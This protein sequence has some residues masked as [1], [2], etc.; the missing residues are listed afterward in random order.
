VGGAPAR[1]V[2]RLDRG[3][4]ETPVPFPTSCSPQAWA[5]ATPFLLLRIML[6]LEPHP[7]KGFTLDPIPG[8]IHG[9]VELHGA[10]RFDTRYDVGIDDNEIY[11]RQSGISAAPE[12]PP[13]V[14]T[15]VAAEQTNG[16]SGRTL[17]RLRRLLRR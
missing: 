4:V 5:A 8:A 12:P 15:A 11:V 10:R 13:T 9:D 1:T 16:H 3:D 17:G 7:T 14:Q 6:G 2:R